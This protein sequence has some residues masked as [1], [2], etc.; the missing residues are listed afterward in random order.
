MKFSALAIEQ[1]PDILTQRVFCPRQ[2]IASMVLVLLPE[3]LEHIEFGAVG[4]EIA[5]E[6]VVL[7]HP[8]PRSVVIKTVMDSSVIQSD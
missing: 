7:D 4:R 2:E 6:G 3:D 8:A 5:E 1:I